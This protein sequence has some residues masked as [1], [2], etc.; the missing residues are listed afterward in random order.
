M[1]DQTRE[2]VESPTD[3]RP[4]DVQLPRL[5]GLESDTPETERFRLRPQA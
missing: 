5:P 4:G 1:L 2:D 3:Q